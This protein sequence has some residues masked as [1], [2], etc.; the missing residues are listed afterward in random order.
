M[1]LSQK[2]SK[3]YDRVIQSGIGIF[4]IVIAALLLSGGS[5]LTTIKRNSDEVPGIIEKQ[6]RCDNKWKC[7]DSTE[8]VRYILDTALKGRLIRGVDRLEKDVHEVK[9]VVSKKFKIPNPFG[10]LKEPVCKNPDDRWLLSNKVNYPPTPKAMS[11]LS[12]FYVK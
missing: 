4:V 1:P 2:H 7:H 12:L 11:G 8:T 6:N 9:M 5:Q 10:E 3:V